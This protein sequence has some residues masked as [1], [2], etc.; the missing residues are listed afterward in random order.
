[1][2][3]AFI[4][5]E[6]S[7]NNPREFV[8]ELQIIF[9]L[10]VIKFISVKDK[11]FLLLF[12]D[13]KSLLDTQLANEQIAYSLEQ[14]LEL[15][16]SKRPYLKLMYLYVIGNPPMFYC[17]GFVIRNRIKIVN[18]SGI[19]NTYSVL[20]DEVADFDEGFFEELRREFLS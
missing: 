6:V 19:G 1:M 11:K 4:F 7:L 5:F 8:Q 14:D 18:S 17:E 12:H 13:I 15:F 16:A 3:V 10:S 9:P 20:F 2:E